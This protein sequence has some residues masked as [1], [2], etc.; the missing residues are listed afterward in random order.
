MAD[1]SSH[2][3]SNASDSDS[4]H[5]F[6]IA[7][8][9]PS[10]LPKPPAPAV[11]RNSQGEL[12]EKHEA[13]SDHDLEKQT[14]VSPR[15]SREMAERYNPYFARSPYQSSM[16]SDE[17]ND[18]VDQRLHLESKA[19]KILLYLSGPCVLL[20]G[21][22]CIWSLVVTLFTVLTYPLRFFSASRRSLSE[23][24]RSLLARSNRLQLRAIYSFNITQGKSVSSLL[25]VHVLSPFTAM[26]V[27]L[28]AWAV[29]IYW[30]FA[31]M[32]GDPDGTEGGNDGRAT[33]LGLRAYWEMWLCKAMVQ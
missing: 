18:L 22:L 9:A 6:H 13:G 25:L 21:L 4:Q 32:I 20:S 30:V 28:S 17:D 27:S 14:N 23:E 1:R 29:A 19:I 33:V 8:N 12:N 15:R 10:T 24:L 31:A 2:R 7:Q 16:S 3:H 26:A 11:V 5:T